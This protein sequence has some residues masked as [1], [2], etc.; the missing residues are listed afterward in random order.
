VLSALRY[1][2]IKGI[3]HQDIKPG[4][5]LLFLN[6]PRK[7]KLTNFGLSRGMHDNAALSFVG[8][9]LYATPEVYPNSGDARTRYD[10]SVD[11]WSLG[12]V[13]WLTLTGCQMVELEPE[14]YKD[15]EI[16]REIKELWEPDM[17]LLDD[18]QVSKE[19]QEFVLDMLELNPSKRPSKFRENLVRAI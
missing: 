8:T 17:N 4:N 3:I 5:I 10:Y 13:L 6:L 16:V 12:A 1:L 15:A 11:I 7:Y 18:I 9:H 19:G 14:H 2:H